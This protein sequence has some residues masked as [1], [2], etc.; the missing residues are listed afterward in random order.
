MDGAYLRSDFE[1]RRK[2]KLAGL[3]FLT[4]IA[5]KTHVWGVGYSFV[6]FHERVSGLCLRQWILATPVDYTHAEMVIVLQVRRWEP[7]QKWLAALLLKCLPT[8]W[9]P[10]FFI[11]RVKH[12]V[13]QDM[14]IWESK[15]YQPLPILS[16]ADGEIM[17]YR[18][19]C[20]Q[21]YPEAEDAGRPVRSLGSA[22]MRPARPA[23]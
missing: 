6:E 18:K 5:A 13:R 14:T 15:R 20:E 23:A 17:T 22:S 7:G 11:S 1:F 10:R 12:D 21:F 8:S 16:R 3:S 19:Y 2:V 9:L 4:D